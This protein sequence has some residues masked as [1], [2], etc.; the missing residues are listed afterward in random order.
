MY[1]VTMVTE[2]QTS[3]DHHYHIVLQKMTVRLMVFFTMPGLNEDDDII[4][5]NVEKV[6]MCLAR[7]CLANAVVSM[8][9]G[10]HR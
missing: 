10:S 9:E 4:N 7:V 5:V 2:H 3:T 6:L 8:L 1:T